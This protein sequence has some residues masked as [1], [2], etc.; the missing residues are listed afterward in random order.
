VVLSEEVVVADTESVLE[1][2]ALMNAV[3]ERDDYKKRKDQ[4]YLERNHVVALL[5]RHYDSF[6][7]V[8]AIEGWDADWHNCIYIFLPTG[9]ISYH[10]HKDHLYLFEDVRYIAPENL[11][12]SNNYDGH[13]KD[14]VHRRIFKHIIV[15]DHDRKR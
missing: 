8:T 15:K 13:T 10:F 2:V 4:A 9:Q 5:A 14:D 12:P 11:A 3:A 6:R 1:N 7:T